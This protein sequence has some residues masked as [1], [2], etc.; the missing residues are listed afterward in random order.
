[1]QVVALAGAQE[2]GARQFVS[3]GINVPEADRP[4]AGLGKADIDSD[5]T[6]QLNLEAAQEMRHMQSEIDGLRREVRAA[7]GFSATKF[8]K[9]LACLF[10]SEPSTVNCAVP[11]HNSSCSS[12]LARILC[13]AS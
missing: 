3:L 5:A 7:A 8:S 1:M 10:F 11:H 13:H 4:Y 6:R 9:A 12:T 2:R